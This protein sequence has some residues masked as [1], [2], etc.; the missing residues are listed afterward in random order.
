MS[1]SNHHY[2]DPTDKMWTFV[3]EIVADEKLSLYDLV[4]PRANSLRVFIDKAKD[5]EKKGSGITS[6]ECSTVCRR[7]LHAFVVDGVNLGI[8]A[9]PE[10][11]VSSPGLER[12]LRLPE[13]F[14]EAIGSKV[15][16]VAKDRFVVGILEDFK[17]E[18]ILIRESPDKDVVE[19]LYR[20]LKK[21][22][23]VFY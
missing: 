12:E 9:E 21:G 19:I 6:G 17:D 10:L 23:I 14:M 13:H 16:V 2:I 20:N 11:E 15:K 4:K 8:S 3:S 1:N 5:D 7:L 18:V 22:Q